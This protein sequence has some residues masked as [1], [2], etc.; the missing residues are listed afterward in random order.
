M[1]RIS[2]FLLCGLLALVLAFASQPPPSLA[3]QTTPPSGAARAFCPEVAPPDPL[4]AT[5]AMDGRSAAID[6]VIFTP[7]SEDAGVVVVRDIAV[8][9]PTPGAIGSAALVTTV[10]TLP[11]HRCILGSY[12]YPSMIMTV[13]SGDISILVEHWPG[14]ADAPEVV[15]IPLGN[16]Q[17]TRIEPAAGVSEITTTLTAEDWLTIENESFVGFSNEQDVPAVFSVAGIKPAGDPSGG[18]GGGHIG[19]QP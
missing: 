16:G 17:P 13:T 1:R 3:L 9:F 10:V 14:G 15:K 19:R 2:A 6:P 7:T 8:P 12:F 5:W 11:P 4:P 18:G